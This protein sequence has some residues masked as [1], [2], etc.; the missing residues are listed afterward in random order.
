M[1]VRRPLE[2]FFRKWTMVKK[3]SLLPIP[4][5]TPNVTSLVLRTNWM[6]MILV[7]SYEPRSRVT[8]LDGQIFQTSQGNWRSYGPN[9]I[10]IDTFPITIL[11]PQRSSSS[12]K[13]RKICS[14]SEHSA[15][16][17]RL[18]FSARS[19]DILLSN[20]NAPQPRILSLFRENL[21]KFS[22]FHTATPIMYYVNV[23]INVSSTRSLL[24]GSL[25]ASS[26]KLR[27]FT[28]LFAY[29]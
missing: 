12:P 1:L 5:L 19:W 3:G 4:F 15:L 11:L 17:D 26:R 18:F 7:P 22:I 6:M 29:T 23:F 14:R 21:R 9:G 13:K 10:S 16:G 27:G 2:V 20:Q 28:R 24:K 8:D 25:N